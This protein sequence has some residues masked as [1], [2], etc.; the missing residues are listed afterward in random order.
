MQSRHNIIFVVFACFAVQYQAYI[1]TAIG[2]FLYTQALL[3]NSNGN[4]T[5][6]GGTE[7]FILT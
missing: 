4:K 1:S 5:T 6:Y 3:S 2:R 7:D